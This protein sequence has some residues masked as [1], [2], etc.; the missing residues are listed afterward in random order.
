MS[1]HPAKGEE[2]SQRKKASH[3]R[4]NSFI[5]Y[6]RSGEFATNRLDEQELVTLSLHLLQSCL[7][8]VGGDGARTAEKQV[9][10]NDEKRFEYGTTNL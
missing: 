10:L 3:C 6:G 7:V 1:T 8:Y 9:V 5:L 2:D 4:A